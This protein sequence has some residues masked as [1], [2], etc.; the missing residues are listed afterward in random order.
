M[1]KEARVE[2][3]D[4]ETD[5]CFLLV[6]HCSIPNNALKKVKLNKFKAHSVLS[7]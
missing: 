4:G 3:A 6:S 5:G 2:W 7:N 1:V